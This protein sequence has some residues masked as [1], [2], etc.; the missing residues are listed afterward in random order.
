MKTDVKFR[1]CLNC[2]E[3]FEIHGGTRP[4]GLCSAECRRQRH[5]YNVKQ[6]RIRR[7]AEF[8]RL[9]EIVASMQAAI[10]A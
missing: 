1:D 4:A 8:S 10:A 7:A 6:Y 9:R 5:A 3:T 2:G